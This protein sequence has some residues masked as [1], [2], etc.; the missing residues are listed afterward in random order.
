MCTFVELIQNH[1]MMLVQEL[2]STGQ[3]SSFLERI[4][5]GQNDYEQ[6]LNKIDRKKNQSKVGSLTKR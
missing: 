6:G 2:K 4:A 3:I 1:T 5:L